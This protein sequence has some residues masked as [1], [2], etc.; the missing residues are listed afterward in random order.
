MRRE[1]PEWR[2]K[3]DATLL[4][5]TRPEGVARGDIAGQKHGRREE[6]TW[7]QYLTSVELKWSRT[8][9]V[10]ATSL[11]CFILYK[12]KKR[13]RDQDPC[14]GPWSRSLVQDPLPGAL[15]RSLVQEPLPGPWSR[16]LVSLCLR[17]RRALAVGAEPKTPNEVTRRPACCRS[18]TGRWRRPAG[19]TWGSCSPA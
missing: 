11:F 15:S 14:S 19:R 1:R 6:R 8:D 2:K 7:N 16:S 10:V 4:F 5:F 17:L 9:S 12:K 18:W 3:T 13:H